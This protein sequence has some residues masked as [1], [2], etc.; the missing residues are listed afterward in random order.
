M[1]ERAQKYN[2]SYNELTTLRKVECLGPLFLSSQL[3]SS[4]DQQWS[5]GRVSEEGNA[6]FLTRFYDRHSDEG[7]YSFLFAM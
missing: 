2:C 6:I 4:V 3:V 7:T 5:K 1:A